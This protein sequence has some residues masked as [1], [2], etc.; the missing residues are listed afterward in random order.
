MKAKAGS[1]RSL[2]IKISKLLTRLMGTIKDKYYITDINETGDITTNS[3]DTKQ[4]IRE[5]YN[6]FYANKFDNLDKMNKVLKDTNYQNSLKN[7]KI[8]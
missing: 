4:I 2:M 1:L 8:A 5:Y 3:T 6:K 7:K